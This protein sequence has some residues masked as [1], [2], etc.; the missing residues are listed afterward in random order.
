MIGTA[1]LLLLILAVSDTRNSAPL[2]NLAPFIVGLVV[3]GI[4]MA[5]GTN[6]G[7]AINPARDFG[8]RLASF[9]TGYENAW[10][11]QYGQLYFWVPI[12]APVIGGLIGAGLYQALVARFLP[13]EE[14]PE[15]GGCLPPP[16][17]SPPEISRTEPLPK[18]TLKRR[19]HPCLTLSEQS[20]RE[21]RAPASWSLITAATR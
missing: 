2:A 3:V 20:I 12:V 8:P 7:Y 10:R 19:H 15:A 9:L 18:P 21:R 6:A 11:D 17:T 5:W 1:I 14:E 16:T 4:G 13:E